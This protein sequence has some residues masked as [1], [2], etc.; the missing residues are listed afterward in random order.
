MVE[1]TVAR[2]AYEAG[3][4]HAVVLLHDSAGG[5]LLPILVGQAEGGAIALAMEGIEPPRP[6]THDLLKQM[7]DR[8]GVSVASILI[9]DVRDET[10]FAQISLST[11][12]GLLEIDSRPSDAIALA[13]RARA[14]IRALE[15]V[16]EVAGV[17]ADEGQVH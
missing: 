3:S 2:V 13:L 17:S 16:L 5:R 4:D 15:R 14:P 9:D 1:L 8:L 12:N 11:A 6:Q 10:F 7:L